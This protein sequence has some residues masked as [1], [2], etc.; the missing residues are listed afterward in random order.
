MTAVPPDDLARGLADLCRFERGHAEFVV[1]ADGA[2]CYLGTSATMRMLNGESV[3]RALARLTRDQIIRPGD[4]IHLLN[5][6]GT[7]DTL[8]IIR[9]ADPDA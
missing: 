8:R 2:L 1:G 9:R 5:T 6:H 4:T 3:D 7:V